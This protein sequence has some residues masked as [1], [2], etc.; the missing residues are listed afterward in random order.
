MPLTRRE[1]LAT[2]QRLRE[3]DVRTWHSCRPLSLPAQGVQ[4]GD[5]RAED[6]LKRGCSLVRSYSLAALQR[7]N[8][9]SS[10]TSS[11]SL[12]VIRADNYFNSHSASSNAGL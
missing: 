3:G 10:G 7:T 11:P 6:K 9:S 5:G 2:I 4:G 12:S 1:A 8:N